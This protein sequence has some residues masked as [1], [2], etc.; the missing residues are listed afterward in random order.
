MF[1]MMLLSILLLSIAERDQK[2]LV[3]IYKDK[4]FFIGTQEGMY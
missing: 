2:T 4:C 1:V 3:A